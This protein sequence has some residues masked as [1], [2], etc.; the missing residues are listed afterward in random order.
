MVIWRAVRIYTEAVSGMRGTEIRLTRRTGGHVPARGE[1][2]EICERC[3]RVTR[4]CRE[5]AKDAR[6]DVI[7]RNG[8]KIHE[9][10]KIILVWNLRGVVISS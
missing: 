9:F 3:C 1:D 5:H 2:Q 4:S 6:V 10:R 7:D 8:A